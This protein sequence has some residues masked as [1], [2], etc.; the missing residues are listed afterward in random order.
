MSSVETEDCL[1]D[2][3]FFNTLE[4]LGKK[5]IL[6]ILRFFVQNNRELRYQEIQSGLKINTKTLVDRLHDLEKSGIIVRKQDPNSYKRVEY[7][8]QDVKEELYEIV[9]AVENFS[10]KVQELGITK[11]Y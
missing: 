11:Q 10:I 9:T 3:N 8:L 6:T 1:E 5:H 2:N 7:Y 4:L